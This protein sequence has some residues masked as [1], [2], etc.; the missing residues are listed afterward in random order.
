M[1]G[2]HFSTVLP[3]LG[4]I[5]RLEMSLSCTGKGLTCLAFHLLPWSSRW[6]EFP[7][8]GCNPRMCHWPFQS[9]ALGFLP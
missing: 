7:A 4:E 6:R 2:F 8:L 5:L 3:G 1:R 9:R